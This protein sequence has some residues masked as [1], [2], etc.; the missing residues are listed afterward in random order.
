MEFP[1]YE[2]AV[3][4]GKKLYETPFGNGNSYADR[5]E[6]G[7]IGIVQRYPKFD[8]TDGKVMPL[9]VAIK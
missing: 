3:D 4:Q 1:P 2:L 6:N 8:P 5:F 7:G 9:H